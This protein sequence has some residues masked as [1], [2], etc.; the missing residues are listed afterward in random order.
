MRGPP[1]SRPCVSCI[2]GQLSSVFHWACG[3]L[4]GGRRQRAAAEAKSTSHAVCYS[5]RR[6]RRATSPVG[7]AWPLSDVSR[8]AD[9]R[10]AVGR[11]IGRRFDALRRPSCNMWPLPRS[12]SPTSWLAARRRR[13]ERPAALG[14]G[15]S[16]RALPRRESYVKNPPQ[17]WTALLMVSYPKRSVLFSQFGS[18]DS[19]WWGQ[20]SA[21]GWTRNH[22]GRRSCC[23]APS[24]SAP[25][26]WSRWSA[27][28]AFVK[29]LLLRSGKSLT[30]PSSA[31][32]ELTSHPL[33]R[34][35]LWPAQLLLPP[36]GA[37]L[38]GVSKHLPQAGK[39]STW[40]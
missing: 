38:V 20:K 8:R 15:R 5:Q 12:T 25:S 14:E 19:P 7:R 40:H 3:S 27:T 18:S 33:L 30:R 17:S 4:G 11:P 6:R 22:L 35:L 32:E 2:S 29:W 10:R 16:V 34:L 9:S 21:K 24:A 26:R 28:A 31:S 39:R 37:S 36:W 1:S 23:P 13:F